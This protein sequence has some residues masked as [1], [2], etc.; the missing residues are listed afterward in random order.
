[1]DF[2]Y[3]LTYILDDPRWVGKVVPLGFLM[4]VAFIPLLGLAALA[5]ALGY[6]LHISINVRNALTYPLPQWTDVSEMFRAGGQVML[7]IVVYNLPLVI[8][9]SAIG[10]TITGIGSGFMGNS[11]SLAIICCLTP[12]TLVYILLA[13]PLFAI[14]IAEYI[15]T[16]EFMALYRLVHLFDVLRANISVVREWL[17]YMVLLNLLLALLLAVPCLGW[18]LFVLFA[19][20]THGHLL[21]QFALKLGATNRATPRNRTV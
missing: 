20:T 1:M 19:P 4:L 8:L 15:D 11:I 3:A 5:L 9:S 12:L 6:M 7:G 2:G 13:W 17:I 14:G 16:G 18:L 10:W 21:G